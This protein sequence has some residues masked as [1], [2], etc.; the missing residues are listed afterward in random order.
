MIN[1]YALTYSLYKWFSFCLNCFNSATIIALFVK[2]TC[3]TPAQIAL[4]LPNSYGFTHTT[5]PNLNLLTQPLQDQTN[6]AFL[7][8]NNLH[9]WHHQIL[10]GLHSSRFVEVTKITSKLTH[11]RKWHLL[12]LICS[13]LIF[14][15]VSHLYST[16]Q[17]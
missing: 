16:V 5:N 11:S 3:F 12:W 9:L 7:T 2:L 10:L 14:I 6:F 17:W 15:W 4:L 1:W 13:R 8:R